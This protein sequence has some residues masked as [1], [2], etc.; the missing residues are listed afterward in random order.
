M[1]NYGVTKNG[2]VLKRLD[3]ILEEIH[4]DLTAGFGIDTR[5]SKS[6]FLNCLVTTFANQVA[7]LWELGQDSYYAKYPAT[8][9]GINLDNAV[10]YGGIR[11]KPKAKT[12]YSLLCTGDDGT[13][14]TEGTIVSTVTKPEV[15]L[16]A[17]KSFKIGRDKCNRISVIVAVPRKETYT[18]SIN[19]VIYSYFSNN[20]NETDILTGLKSAI[21]NAEYSVVIDGN[22]LK[23][24]DTFAT[25][26]NEILLSNNLTTKSVSTLADFETVQYGRFSLP[27]GLIHKIVT[28]V[29]GFTDVVNTLEPIYGRDRQTDVELRHDYLRKCAIR[30]NTMIESII[31]EILSS[32]PNV[33]MACGYENDLNETDARGL[34]PHSIEIIVDG[35]DSEAIAKAILRRKAGGIQTYGNVVVNVPGNY[36]DSIP[37]K[38][39]RP[40]YVY[41]WLQVTLHG[42]KDS[43]PVNYVEFTIREIIE[44]YN[45]IN[46]GEDLLVQRISSCLYESINGLTYVDI[47]HATSTDKGY[48][49][50][51]ADF[52]EGNIVITQRQKIRLDRTRIEVK[53]V[54]DT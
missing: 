25:R 9:T 21:K 29:P 54:A 37:I 18:I 11:R 23:I 5:L 14:V 3:K 45:G 17:I 32:V 12:V 15:R 4:S 27:T 22:V 1:A 51:K 48:V 43:L 41:T 19:G 28:N 20:G 6:S 39:N 38:F 42:N 16:N 44:R 49:P 50:K 8:A 7:E 46:A 35:G 2:F 47:V 52:K 40:D 33:E 30:S 31:S 10:Q 24:E 13:V 34:P 26:L 36:G 53:F